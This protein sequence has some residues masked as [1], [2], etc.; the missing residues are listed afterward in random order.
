MRKVQTI[1]A[2]IA[3]CLALVFVAAAKADPITGVELNP[4]VP[5]SRI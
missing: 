5:G 3:L 1:T 4:S 2:S